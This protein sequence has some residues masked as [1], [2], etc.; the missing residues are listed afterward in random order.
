MENFGKSMPFYCTFFCAC[1]IINSVRISPW[2]WDLRQGTQRGFW[3]RR[4]KNLAQAKSHFAPAPSICR[5]RLL[6]KGEIA[7]AKMLRFARY[8]G[9]PR[10]EY[11]DCGVFLNLTTFSY[12]STRKKDFAERFFA[13]RSGERFKRGVR[14]RRTTRRVRSAATTSVRKEFR[15]LIPDS[16]SARV[17]SRSRSSF[18]ARGR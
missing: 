3:V 15:E 14:L 8:R 17:P 16:G 7:R 13:K 1:G 5:L 11:S 6:R 12:R 9:K 10:T 18:R 4:F 2:E